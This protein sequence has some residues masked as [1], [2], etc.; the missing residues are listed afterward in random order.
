MIDPL[1]TQV[2]LTSHGLAAAL[3]ACGALERSTGCQGF[4]RAICLLER[5][6]FPQ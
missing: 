6:I 3:S 4:A 2:R 5:G 1:T